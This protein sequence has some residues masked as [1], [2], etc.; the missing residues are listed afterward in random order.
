MKL[1]TKVWNYLQDL[2]VYTGK[3]RGEIEDLDVM[4]FNRPSETTS[5]LYTDRYNLSVVKQKE[6]L[7]AM[8]RHPSAQ[9]RKRVK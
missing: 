1:L 8:Q 9:S 2:S 6:R 5:A 4:S 3:N 7:E